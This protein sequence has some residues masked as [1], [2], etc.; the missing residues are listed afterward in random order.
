MKPEAQEGNLMKERV[1]SWTDQPSRPRWKLPPGAVDAHVHVFG[2]AAEFPFSRLAKY[3]PQDA[4]PEMLFALRDYLGFARN[5]I[6]QA[7]CHGTDN[8]A[9]LAAIAKS[10]GR[11]RGVAVVDP[12]IS[13]AELR[14]LHAGGIRGVRFNF[15]KRLVDHS[16]KDLFLELS[17]RI[18]ALGWHV[19][20]YFEAELLEE[21]TPFLAALPTTVVIDHLGRPDLT[22]GP[23]GADLQRFKALLDRHLHLW[24]KVSG[25]ERLSPEGPPFDDFVAAVRP[26]VERY[27]D[28]ILWGTDWPHPNMEHRIPDDGQLVDILPRLAPTAELQHRL[29]VANPMR[30]YWPEEWSGAA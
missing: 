18:A 20:V 8:G 21:L 6:V 10:A 12:A 4:T 23:D 24:V 28:R 1:K 29:L 11:A 19:V 25:A 15:L 5:V 13:D 7:S 30:L 26:V 14:Q 9:T 22:A 2:P 27:P 17:R 3:H 16:P